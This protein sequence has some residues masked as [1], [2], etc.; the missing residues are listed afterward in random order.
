MFA[1][2]RILNV[3]ALVAAACIWYIRQIVSVIVVV[4]AAMYEPDAARAFAVESWNNA[5]VIC[6]AADPP[7]TPTWATKS[8]SAAC[9]GVMARDRNSL[10]SVFWGIVSSFAD[11]GIGMVTITSGTDSKHGPNSYHA[12]GRAID[13]RFWNV[14]DDK[15]LDVAI[16]IKKWLPKYYDV[17]TEV[18][19]YH[20]EADT[21]KEEAA[22]NKKEVIK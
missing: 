7:Y 2:A 1:P 6:D 5:A 10:P 22:L 21:K 4:A 9:L 13:V 20:L 18:D 19:H 16:T 15:R 14:P 3:V 11:H 17:V 8:R 12:Q